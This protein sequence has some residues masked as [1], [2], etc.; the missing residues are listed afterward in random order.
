[1]QR[2]L[3]DYP[4]ARYVVITLGGNDSA[5]GLPS[6]Y[7]FYDAYRSMVEA[8]LAAGRI[9][10]V[11]RTVIWHGQPTAHRAISDPSQYSL[12]NQLQRLLSDYAGRVVVGPDLWTDFENAP[13]NGSG[14]PLDGTGNVLVEGD[15]VHVANPAGIQKARSLWAD[16]LTSGAY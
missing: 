9:P 6:S 13:K 14:Q 1:V 12:D 11:P 3:S 15:L 5:N 10:V 4:Q 2:V 16:A 8:V 7:S